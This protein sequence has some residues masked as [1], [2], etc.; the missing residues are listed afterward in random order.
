MTATTTPSDYPPSYPK[1]GTFADLLKWHLDWGTRPDCS[2]TDCTKNRPWTISDFAFLVCGDNIL[3]RSA[4]KNVDNWRTGR[5]PDPKTDAGRIANI[6]SEFFGTDDSLS[7]W[8]TDFENALERGRKEQTSRIA[9]RTFEV[10][11]MLITRKNNLLALIEDKHPRPVWF[12][13]A[14]NLIAEIEHA[15]RNDETPEIFLNKTKHYIHKVK[16]RV[17]NTGRWAYYFVLGSGPNKG[18]PIVI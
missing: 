3:P 9:R 12:E 2:T 4:R 17:S 1:M 18:I 5:L 10:S 16:A 6:F 11:S 14:E 8:K 15:L 13:Q 7:P